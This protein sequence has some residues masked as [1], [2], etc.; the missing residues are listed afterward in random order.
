M[1]STHSRPLSTSLPSLDEAIGGFKPGS[2]NII[3]GVSAS[4]KTTLLRRILL[5]AIRLGRK[6]IY[7]CEGLPE[8]EWAALDQLMPRLSYLEGSDRLYIQTFDTRD[9]ASFMNSNSEYQAVLVDNLHFTIPESPDQPVGGIFRAYSDGATQILKFAQQK[10]VP[11]VATMQ[12]RRKLAE[13][14]PIVHTLPALSLY[15]IADTIL[16]TKEREKVVSVGKARG[17]DPTSLGE[18]HL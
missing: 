6:C 18:Y 14:T 11:V 4:Y 3:A 8:Y 12:L 2:F 9:F 7:F 13:T 17:I 5:E 15:E 10:M 16:F 1:M